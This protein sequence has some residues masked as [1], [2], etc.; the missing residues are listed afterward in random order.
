MADRLP[1]LIIGAGAAGLA[2]AFHLKAAGVPVVVLEARGRVGG[3]IHT[4]HD[5]LW[6][7]PVELGAEFMH[8]EP[9]ATLRYLGL[10]NLQAMEVRGTSWGTYEGAL[11]TFDDVWPAVMDVLLHPGPTDRPFGEVLAEAERQGRIRGKAAQLAAGY[12]EGYN[13]A[14]LHRVSAHALARDERAAEGIDGERN[15]RFPGGYDRLP[16]ALARALDPARGE[17]RLNSI[18]TAVT[19]QPG[20]VRFKVRMRG[21]S[22]LADVDGARAVITLPLALLQGPPDDRGAVRFEPELS[23]MRAAADRLTVGPVVRL[24][25][26]F[27]TPFW[28]DVRLPG[29][30]H[31]L[32]DLGFFHGDG[33]PVPVW[34]TT[35][36]LQTPVLTGWAAGSAA[37]RL[38]EADTPA[39]IEAGLHSLAQLFAVSAGRLRDALVAAHASDW[40]H[41]PFARGAYTYVPVGGLDAPAVLARS[42]ADTLFFAGEATH[43]DGFMATVHGALETGERAAA[44]VLASLG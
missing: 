37:D 32:R 30:P 23:E 13:A 8:G 24:L 25:L 16:L 38:R 41:D 33:V 2:A 21:A 12:A 3:R 42:V 29:A 15:F 36:P 1:V 44:E 5:P 35:A 18:V 28:R 22:P 27:R 34:W 31:G 17:L 9:P 20:R 4:V 7:V 39:L 43:T 6:P 14:H 10:S 40:Q 11:T 26:R 19:W